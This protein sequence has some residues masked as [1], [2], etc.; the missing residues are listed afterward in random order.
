MVASI[1][2]YVAGG[3]KIATEKGILSGSTGLVTWNTGLDSVVYASL[4][5]ISLGTAAYSAS[6]NGVTWTNTTGATSITADFKGS[7]TS[8]FE[9][10]AVGNL[11]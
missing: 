7:T 5:P 10:Y 6:N 2:G 8:I 3:R 4:V 11:A 9:G 1:T